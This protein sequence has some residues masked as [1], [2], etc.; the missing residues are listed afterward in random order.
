M[1]PWEENAWDRQPFWAW[2][3]G[4]FSM[5][6]PCLPLWPKDFFLE[7]WSIPLTSSVLPWPGK[8]QKLIKYFPL[9][10]PHV[11][12]A[13]YAAAHI[14]FCEERV[15][16][17][18]RKGGAWEKAG[19]DPTASRTLSSTIWTIF[20]FFLGNF[21]AADAPPHLF[22]GG[23]PAREPLPDLN[24]LAVPYNPTWT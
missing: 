12:P 23:K 15:Y 18:Q 3:G 7:N 19:V 13:F 5:L 8:T 22:F 20:V 16:R 6:P 10:K 17:P 2:T 1:N 14:K 21:R 11:V 4:H 9:D 24:S